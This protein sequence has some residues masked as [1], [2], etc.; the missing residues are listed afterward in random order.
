MKHILEYCQKERDYA[1]ASYFFNARGTGLE[2]TPLGMLRS[3]LFQL[4]EHEPPLY[5]QLLPIFRRKQEEYSSEDWEWREPELK[6][7]FLSEISK[8]RQS[9]QL[10]FIIDALDECNERDV[11][12]VAEFLQHLSANAMNAGIM[13][14]ICLSSRHYPF[15][16]FKR[17]QELV[18][19][20]EK[21]HDEDIIIYVHSKLTEKNEAIEEAIREKASGIFMWVVLV[22]T[23]LNRAYDEDKIDA[24]NQKLN[25]IPADLE[26]VCL[27]HC[28]IGTTLTRMRPP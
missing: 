4:L 3:L 12:K 9:K 17:Y 6:T 18:L 28:S 21:E 5:D 13:L 16:R 20:K 1:I 15:I 7:F 25:E 22:I 8:C 10:L 14:N 26:K 11:Q 2:K 24:M 19:E 27:R 23:I